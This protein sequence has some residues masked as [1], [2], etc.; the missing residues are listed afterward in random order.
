MR[1][2]L[3]PRPHVAVVPDGVR[4]SATAPSPL[5]Q[6]PVVA[7]AGH[8]YAWKGVDLLLQALAQ[9]P[10]A[11]GLIVG[12]HAAEPDLARVE[13]L[14]ADLGIARRVTFTGLVDPATVTRHLQHALI[15][16]L[17]NPPSALSTHFTSPLKLF[18]YMAARR[19]IVASDLPAMREVLR[20]GENALLVPAGDPS[21]LAAAIRRLQQDRALAARLAESAYRDA[22]G[23]SWAKRAER[24][25]AL[26]TEVLAA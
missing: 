26:F 6:E 23:Y 8:L 4:L 14:A 3:G 18:E 9:V 16:V 5:P 11:K 25:D 19:A 20:D 22:A 1:L 24:L 17:P 13:Q 2:R 7:Y 15:L 21:A 10:D 12:G